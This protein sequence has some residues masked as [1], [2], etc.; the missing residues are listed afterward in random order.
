MRVATILFTASL[1]LFANAQSTTVDQAPTTTDPSAAAAS[2]AQAEM[3]RCIQACDPDDVNCKADCVAVPSP[4]DKEA[5]A[6]NQCVAEC[7]IGE[8]S[9][10]ENIAYDTCVRGCISTN[11]FPTADGPKPTGGNNDDNNDD[12]DD[13]NNND[14]GNNDD[15]D[16]NNNNGGTGT[17]GNQQTGTDG[18]SSPTETGG[19]AVLK[20]SLV[21]VVGLVAAVMAL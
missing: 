7:D 6:T 16:D 1:A 8:G 17:E 3:V 18:G 20:G 9:E 14:D 15:G 11:F 5:N 19:A 2:S 12:G 13:S 10:A 4:N 21:G